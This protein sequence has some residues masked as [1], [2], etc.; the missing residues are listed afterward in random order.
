MQAHQH[1]GGAA[2]AGELTGGVFFTRCVLCAI[3]PAGAAGADDRL[4]PVLHDARGGWRAG[5]F[6]PDC[7]HPETPDH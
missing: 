1:H 7:E 6:A 2:V 5:D 3:L 4:Q